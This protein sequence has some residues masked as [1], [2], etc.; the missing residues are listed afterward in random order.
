LSDPDL[1]A[2]P[3]S[4]RTLRSE[5]LVV[6]AV[7]FFAAAAYAGLQFVY[8]VL[9]VPVTR[10]VTVRYVPPAFDPFVFVQRILSELIDLA[11]VALVAHLLG[12][13]GEGMRRLGFDR[14]RMRS[15][16]AFGAGLALVAL[17]AVAGATAIARALD[18]PLRP[19]EAVNAD[20]SLAAIP[21]ALLMSGVAAV[22]EEVI[23]NGYVITRL[24]DL[25]WNRS[26]A[27]L[28]SALLRGSYHLYQ[29]VGGF[30]YNV[31]GGLIAGRIFQRT[32]R[33]MPLVVAH[34]AIDVSAFVLAYFWPG[35]PGWMH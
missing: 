9:H 35:R 10:P 29:G 27:L 6:L 26:R 22:S 34:F 8:D 13:S 31:I 20:A 16:V 32:K 1:G 33:V 14:T 15:D 18:A 3:T 25:G 12:R 19:V 11:P 23:V 4:G 30:I 5:L 28:A 7:S 17:V 21:L 24:E 2:A